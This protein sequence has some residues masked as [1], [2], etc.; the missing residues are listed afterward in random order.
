M[1]KKIIL[2]TFFFLFFICALINISY[3]LIHFQSSTLTI[4]QSFSNKNI[5]SEKGTH[6]GGEIYFKKLKENMYLIS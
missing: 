3:I 6:T 1:T 4:Y 2:L 5:L